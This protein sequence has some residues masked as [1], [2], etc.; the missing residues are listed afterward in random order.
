MSSPLTREQK[1]EAAVKAGLRLRR[2]MVDLGE[3]HV[4][5]DV[6]RAEVERYDATMKGLKDET[7]IDNGKA[8]S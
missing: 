8:S 3:I 2:A 5:L 6:P 4:M 7:K 1:L